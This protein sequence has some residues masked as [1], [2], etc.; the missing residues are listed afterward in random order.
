MGR[1]KLNL[2][3]ISKDASRRAMLNKRRQGLIKKTSE[4]SK[5][6]GV[7][8]CAMVYCENEVRAEV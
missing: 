6:C 4:L 7:R 5:L 2:Q 8:A 1:K 3:W